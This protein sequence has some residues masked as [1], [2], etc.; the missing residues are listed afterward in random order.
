MSNDGKKML[1]TRMISLKV[2]TSGLSISKG[3][4]SI[5]YIDKAGELVRVDQKCTVM[6]QIV[7]QFFGV[8]KAVIENVLFC[9]QEDA[10]WPFE[11]NLKLKG[12]FDEIFQTE[13]IARTIQHLD[14]LKKEHN[15]KV[16]E[17]AKDVIE[18][19]KDFESMIAKLKEFERI[20]REIKVNVKLLETNEDRRPS[21]QSD[22]DQSRLIQEKRKQITLQIQN[23]QLQLNSETTKKQMM[24]SSIMLAEG[25]F[26][27]TKRFESIIKATKIEISLKEK[28]I[29]EA[30]TKLKSLQE[31]EKTLCEKTKSNLINRQNEINDYV[32]T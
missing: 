32:K 29:E 18:K 30:S 7:P 24:E 4:Q 19:R 31:T 11:E 10:L 2:S 15:S 22:V 8:S 13:K 28:D 12:V 26:L 16:N 14:K 23:L 25:E 20:V 17:A 5:K 6:D 3:E 1:S 21:L 27:D 9:H